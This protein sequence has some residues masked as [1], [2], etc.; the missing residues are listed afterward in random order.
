MERPKDVSDLLAR[1]ARQSESGKAGNPGGEDGEKLISSAC[2]TGFVCTY[3]RS[4]AKVPIFRPRMSGTCTRRSSTL[5]SC[6]SGIS[7]LHTVERRLQS[8]LRISCRWLQ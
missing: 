7:R 1:S 4:A 2:W 6:M 3:R 8:D 5:D